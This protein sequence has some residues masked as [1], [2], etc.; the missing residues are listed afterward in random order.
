MELKLRPI[1]QKRLRRL[2]DLV[3]FTLRHFRLILRGCCVFPACSSKFC[4][5]DTPTQTCLVNVGGRWASGAV[6]DEEQLASIFDVLSDDGTLS[7]DNLQTL[8]LAA[9][10]PVGV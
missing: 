4:P 3:C 8:Q 6:L 7:T 5:V 9:N 2:V 1:L 10:L